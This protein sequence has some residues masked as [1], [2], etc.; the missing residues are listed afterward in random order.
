MKK[1]A[2]ALLTLGVLA[3]VYGNITAQ[4][5][6]EPADPTPI[7]SSAWL[8]NDEAQQGA[9]KNTYYRLKAKTP[10]KLEAYRA[11]GGAT[12][13]RKVTLPKGTVISATKRG[14]YLVKTGSTTT[15]D[16]RYGLKQATLKKMKTVGQGTLVLKI[17]ASQATKIKRP[18]YALPYGGG[19][20][21]S[22][23][24]KALSQV[25][26][27]TSNQIR[28]TSDGYLEYYPNHPHTVTGYENYQWT[29]AFD[30]RPTK[31]VK[32]TKATAKGS[33]VLLYTKAKPAGVT[34]SRVAK[35]GAQQYRV[36]L[37]NLHTPYTYT[38]NSLGDDT[39]FASL[40]KIGKTAAY[41]VIGGGFN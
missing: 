11:K 8:H 16:V 27:M 36:S 19:Q 17:K 23:G 9:F 34:S 24:L 31:S 2:A 15:A 10:A 28:I 5:A 18:V 4:A 37:T 32:I 12:V 38:D 26:K 35:S 6:T 22:G 7:S 25:P 20:L 3:G 33:R 30:Q 41:T 14:K 29:Y 39:G 1:Q 13:Q 21:L 40:Y